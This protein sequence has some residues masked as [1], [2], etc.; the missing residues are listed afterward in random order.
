MH[1]HYKISKY[2]NLIFYT[3]INIIINKSKHHPT[4]MFESEMHKL[5]HQ[6]CIIWRHFINL[7]S[8]QEGIKYCEKT[9]NLIGWLSHNILHRRH[10]YG[11]PNREDYICQVHRLLL[12]DQTNSQQLWICIHM[13]IIMAY[14]WLISFRGS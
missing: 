7:F 6:I 5:N 8:L 4:M 12:I 2:N 3:P 9:D 10:K 13:T 1:V 14:L 11:H